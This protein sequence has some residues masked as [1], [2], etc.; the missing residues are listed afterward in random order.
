[1]NTVLI[2]LLESSILL[3]VLYVIYILVLRKENYFNL[4]RYYL[5]FI[6]VI[7]I[8]IPFISFDLGQP[9]MLSAV[10]EPIQQIGK[11]RHD[12]YEALDEWANQS[13]FIESDFDRRQSDV[14]DWNQ[15]MLTS[16][17]S[18]YIG[19]L[20]FCLSR[21]VWM[22]QWILRLYRS[23]KREYVEGLQVLINSAHIAPFSF[24]KYVFVSKETRHSPEFDQILAHENIHI[25][26]RHSLDLLMVQLLAAMLWFNPIIWWLIKSLKTVHEYIAD[27]QMINAGYSLV[28]YQ[29]LLLRQLISNNSYGLVHNFNLSFIKKRITMM[30]NNEKTR[31]GKVRVGLAIVVTLLLSVFIIQ[32]NATMEDRA[33]D[34]E[35]DT[36]DLRIDLPKLPAS[37]FTPISDPENTVT[38]SMEGDRV[39]LDGEPVSESDLDQA[40]RNVNITHQGVVIFKV[41]KDQKMK[42]VRVVQTALRRVNH[43]KILYLGKT[44]I[45][46]RVE[47]PFL[48]PPLPDS[49]EGAQMPVIDDKYIAETG[50]KLLK[51]DLG[52]SQNDYPALVYNFVMDQVNE[53]SSNYVISAKFED[54]DS[55][56]SYLTNLAQIHHGFNKIYDERAQELF[57]KSWVEISNNRQAN[58][59]QYSAVRK[60][61]P[62]AISVAEADVNSTQSFRLLVGG[63]LIT[64][65]GINLDQVKRNLDQLS[66]ESA[67]EYLG[68]GNIEFVLVRQGVGVKELTE[69]GIERE[70]E[71]DLSSLVNEAKQGDHLVIKVL[72]GDKPYFV[73]YPFN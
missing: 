55:Y 38:L 34:V 31:L 22:M 18:I 41:D 37:N 17:M 14:I 2:H 52:N 56:A 71:L 44:E 65:S 4:N 19:G 3:A 28:E 61:I 47:V 48:L 63:R 70:A 36:G 29:T 21:S 43:R 64:D 12:Y 1:M 54:D 62:R 20:L 69:R 67:E 15:I 51:V 6:P 53:G 26:E 10:N 16:L 7:S 60:G 42:L 23:S 13:A 40:L 5:L 39:F 73:S 27:K 32:C 11:V 25:R 35:V 58:K 49:K 30:T 8:I 68:N 59:E 24:L 9:Q 33:L 50:M 72:S 57:G 45:G 66:Y 46:D